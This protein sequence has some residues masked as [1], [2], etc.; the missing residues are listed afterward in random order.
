MNSAQPQIEADDT[1]R[2]GNLAGKTAL[3]TGASSGL[4]AHFAQV[5][6]ARGAAVILAARRL[7]A[8][9]QV[10]V[11]IR[12]AGG[13]ATTAVLDVCDTASVAALETALA[14]LDILINNAGVVRE[15]PALDQT[16]ADWDAVVDTNLKGCF[17]MA[18]VAAR[19]FRAHGRGGQIVN[20]ASILGLRQAGMV[21]PYAVAKAGLIQ[22]T[23]SLALEWARFG[24]SV[25]AIAPGYVETELN[26]EFWASEAGKAMLR[27][28]PQR[29][30]G[31]LGDLDAPL[32][33]LASGASGYMTGAVL[34][35]DGG[36]L[37]SSL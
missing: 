19:A 7:D 3:V 34:T 5:L 15:A 29:R 4:G 10:A 1:T 22:M 26:A 18:Q 33:M 23:K 14:G 8:L 28:I 21:M 24:I 32:L 13:R 36:H 11:A 37:T 17:L 25:N 6:A 9:E 2:P 20:I 30:L 16:E 12:A 31:R 27:R 35:V